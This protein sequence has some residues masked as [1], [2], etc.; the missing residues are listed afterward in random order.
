MFEKAGCVKY[1]FGD[2]VRVF[3]CV[4]GLWIV[5][6]VFI[7][8]GEDV[9]LESFELMCVYFERVGWLFEYILSL[10]GRDG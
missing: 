5:L 8:R 2:G 1:V 3:V 7:C 10:V 9:Y 4:L 6:D